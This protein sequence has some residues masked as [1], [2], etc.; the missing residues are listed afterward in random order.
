MIILY[1]NTEIQI[2]KERKHLDKSATYIAAE[3]A[4]AF[5]R[6]TELK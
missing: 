1:T 6:K 3:L 2:V 4:H 5:T